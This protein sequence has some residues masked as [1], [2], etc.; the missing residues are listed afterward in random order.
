M[1]IKGSQT[2]PRQQDKPFIR[3]NWIQLESMLSDFRPILSWQILIYIF[4]IYLYKLHIFVS[5]TFN[6]CYFLCIFCQ[7]GVDI[8]LWNRTS[9][10]VC[11]PSCK[12]LNGCL[13]FPKKGS[14][15]KHKPRLIRL[16]RNSPQAPHLLGHWRFYST[17]FFI[18]TTVTT[19][20]F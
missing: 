12:V 5:L 18:R 10:Q 7:C 1:E 20:R 16:D 3:I 15:R 9:V 13:V 4:H 17:K 11:Y 8:W 6:Y 19:T 14:I 2:R